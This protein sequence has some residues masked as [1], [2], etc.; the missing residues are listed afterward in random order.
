V[1]RDAYFTEVLAEMNG[2]RHALTRSLLGVAT[3]G[4]EYAGQ[5]PGGRPGLVRHRRFR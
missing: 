1:L 5:E 3:G 2:E 4:E